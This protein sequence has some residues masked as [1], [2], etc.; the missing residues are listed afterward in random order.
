MTIELTRTTTR[1]AGLSPAQ[2]DAG[3]HDLTCSTR[4]LVRDG[5]PVH[6]DDVDLV[7]A[8]GADGLLFQ[9]GDVA[10]AGRGAAA[11]V[12]LR[13]GLE[14]ADALMDVARALSAVRT[15]SE[16]TGPGTGPVVLGALPFDR[17]AE[18]RLTV[19]A[20]LVGRR[21][22]DVWVTVVR[23][24]GDD[25]DLA[26]TEEQV[27]AAALGL[28]PAPVPAGA[29]TFTLTSV[30]EP[31]AYEDL[32]AAA[33]ERI[34]AGDLEKVVLC[35]QVEVVADRPF[36]TGAVL[37]RLATLFPTCMLFKVGDFL[38]AS[39]ELLVERRGT[40]I[41]SLP[42]AGTVGRSGDRANDAAVIAGLLSSTKERNEHALVVDAI[43]DALT[44]QCTSLVTPRVP[45]VL[46]LRN[47][48][49]LA[50]P[51]LGELRPRAS[52][53]PSDGVHRS[54]LDVPTA[55][56]LVASL[57]PTPAVGGVPR[58][59]AMAHLQREEGFDRGPFAGPVGWMD[60]RGDGTFAL[61]L[62]SATVSGNRAVMYAGVGVVRG[63]HPP[64]ELQETQ[65]KLQALLAVLVRP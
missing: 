63:S 18:G 62:R 16:L 41:T 33:V 12:R 26:E 37:R 28:V 9:N 64:T 61:A 1:T 54:P 39:P 57:H 42:L 25:A 2:E 13:G 43:V 53:G 23:G 55:L 32:V 38:G 27:L 3:F 8:A 31:R 56:D 47:V 20:V 29:R 30:R 4:R 34:E 11:V 35:R 40:A 6:A 46:E 45:E 24:P 15:S 36:S 19:P 5:V 65:L 51:L 49:H 52:A 7:A 22:A 21:G 14:D 60:S 10:L 50:T 48:S 17:S 58:A 44:P 59:A